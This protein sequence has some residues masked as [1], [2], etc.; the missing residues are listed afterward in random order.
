MQI[1]QSKIRIW[2]AAL[3]MLI[4]VGIPFK[5]AAGSWKQVI[6]Q[7]SPEDLDRIRAA[8]GAAV[9]DAIPGGRFLLTVSSS[10]DASQIENIHGK[11]P[12]QAS[13]NGSI[14]IPHFVPQTT[15]VNTGLPPV[16]PVDS[17]YGTPARQA[18]TTQPAVDKITLTQALNVATGIGIRIAIIDTGVDEHHPTLVSVLMAGKNYVDSSPIPDELNDPAV[19]GQ[20]T[21]DVLDQAT[22]DVLDQSTVDVLDQATVDVLDAASHLPEFG[23]GTMMAGL[24]HLVAPNAR[25]IPLK[26]F[27]ANGSATEW[28]VVHAIYDAVAMGADVIS[29]SFSST[30]PSKT[31]TTAIQYAASNGVVL[32]GA[33]GNDNSDAPAYPAASEGVVAVSALDLNDQKASFSNYGTYIDL[34]ALGVN[35]ISTYPGG[36]FAMGSGT[37]DSTPLV[38]GVFA[39]VLQHRANS[40]SAKQKVQAGADP[41]NVPNQYKNK[42]GNGRL[43]AYNA[44]RSETDN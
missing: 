15:S 27:D 32:I 33:A 26:A 23:H 8:F 3:L 34:S 38:S 30:T 6:V 12:I 35:L 18:Y 7:C 43:D 39:L 21:V 20:A 10:V 17:W 1:S 22:V 5:A 19:L 40:W 2:C 42:L 28:N 37:S 41:L 9:V 16:G 4:G 25:I 13:D 29:M 31:M 24:V 14:S 44:V 11:G 36:R